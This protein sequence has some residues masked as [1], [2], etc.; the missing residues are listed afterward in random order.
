MK[1][2]LDE[3]MDIRLTTL[4]SGAGH[5]AQTVFKEGL[6]GKPDNKI[7]SVSIKEKRILITQD[8]HFQILFASHRSPLKA[9][10]SSRIPHNSYRMQNIS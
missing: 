3:C 2:K 10:L 4:F 7:Y 1:F 9:S 6:S 5:N 8:M